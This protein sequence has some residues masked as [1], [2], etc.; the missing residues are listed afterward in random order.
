[1]GSLF[2]TLRGW[3]AIP[4]GVKAS[5]GGGL[6]PGHPLPPHTRGLPSGSTRE[7]WEAPGRR[8]TS[9]A[10][11]SVKWGSEGAFPRRW[12]GFAATSQVKC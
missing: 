7:D 4:P 10:S 11:L 8:G 3:M 9:Q 12:P 5:N 6:V 1:M 2:L